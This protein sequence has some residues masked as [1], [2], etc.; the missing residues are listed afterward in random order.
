MTLVRDDGL[1]TSDLEVE[2]A[3]STLRTDDEFNEC[4]G[5][6]VL[7][8]DFNSNPETTEVMFCHASIGDFFRDESESKRSAGEDHVSIGVD[9]AESRI[10][11][12]KVCLQLVCNPTKCPKLRNYALVW[13]HSHIKAAVSHLHKTSELDRLEIGG[14]LLRTLREESVLE[15]WI[16]LRNADDFWTLDTLVPIAKFLDDKRFVDSLTLEMRGWVLGAAQEPARLFIPAA[17]HTAKRWLQ[18]YQW[19]PR[20]C[21]LII[22]QI[23]CLINGDRD[24]AFND[25]P[26]ASDVL[27]LAEWAK[28]PKTAEWNRR[29]AMCLRDMSYFKEAQAHFEAALELD[30]H[31]W[32]ARGG[33]A[34]MFSLSGQHGKA[35]DLYKENVEILDG[36]FEN[37]ELR[38]RLPHDVGSDDLADS[39]R[40]VGEEYLALGDQSNALV[41]FEKALEKSRHRI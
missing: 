31:M 2:A 11:T 39:H 7:E 9:I 32:L 35:L 26:A 15:N 40:S 19:E 21:M 20:I 34:Y 28:L 37:A 1:T 36:A 22:Y 4:A 5:D 12:L 14:L 6:L 38:D 24:E 3:S 8:G 10:L 27:D 13:W 17:E 33:L 18:G 23:R 25:S 30:S 41:Y 16:G 29:V